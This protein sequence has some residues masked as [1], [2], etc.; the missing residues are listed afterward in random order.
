MVKTWPSNA[1][2]V[3]SIP[4]TKDPIYLK[5][6]KPKYLKKKRIRAS[7]GAQRLRICLPIQD[8]GVRSLIQEDPT[9]RGVTKLMPHN[10]RAC[11]P[12]PGSDNYRARMQQ[13]LKLA[14]PRACAPQ[15]E[16][17]PQMRNLCAAAGEE[18][19]LVRKAC[20]ATRPSAAKYK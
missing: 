1:G 18:P 4:G 14:H 15:Q 20:A 2:G 9:C 10:H 12:G 5:A 8:T 16:K 13:E 6:R 17:P 11:A 19:L 3:G 7:L